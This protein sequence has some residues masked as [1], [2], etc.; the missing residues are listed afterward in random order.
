MKTGK[1]FFACGACGARSPRWQGKCDACGEWNTLVEE[2]AAPEPAKAAGG[3]S[4]AAARLAQESSPGGGHGGE[5]GAWGGRLQGLA[6]IGGRS[7]APVALTSIN[8]L[9]ETRAMTGID[10]FDRILG[11]GIVAG[12]A[13]L[14]G[15]EPGIGK[16]TLMLQVARR[17]ATAERPALY[18]S[19]EESLAQ[20]RLR[21]GRMEVLTDDVL[22]LAE[23]RVEAIGDHIVATIP[24]CVVVDSIQTAYSPDAAG[25]P[26]GVPQIRDCAAHLVFLC[27]QLQVPLF[28]VG[29]VTKSGVVAGPRLLEHMVDTVL[30][31]EGDRHHDFR[32]LRAVKNRF[33]STN[34][35]GIF[36]M[37]AKGLTGVAN[38]SGLFLQERPV[39][40]SGSVVT[41]VMEGTRPMLVEIQALCAP[42]GGFG[43]PR[44]S[45]TGL[46]PRRV[47][48]LIA[49][50]EK[51]VGL[52]LFDH[53][54][55]VNV[56]GG[57]KIDEPGADLAALAAMV[58]SYRNQ[59]VD[60][61]TVVV[62]EVGLAGEIRGVGHLGKR[63]TESARL[64][65]SRAVT[66]KAGKERPKA[67]MKV[68]QAANVG[69]AL[70][71]LGL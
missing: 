40:A 67:G 55:Y 14:V 10:E 20:L 5:P 32:I 9:A 48:L 66:S 59:P 46:D 43:S 31:F 11:G 23:T 22:C 33:G 4:R 62:G 61:D 51:R 52:R 25:A 1:T 29:H 37:G 41:P 34:E 68:D 53:D 57:A 21:A 2:H 26:G 35:I 44:R 24:S 63:L 30:Y 7:A 42:N 27:K 49:V 19:G 15:G 71:L 38:P 36:E 16:S 28:L 65:F 58:S 47:N 70:G 45:A 39:G 56:A 64:G 12:S 69:E 3:A 8:P 18:V 17:L 13:T 6:G 60:A 54:V 50:L